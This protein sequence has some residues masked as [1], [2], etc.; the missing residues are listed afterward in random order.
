MAIAKLWTKHEKKNRQG[1]S[2]SSS[3]AELCCHAEDDL[4]AKISGNFVFLCP[5]K[6]P[7]GKCM[8]LRA[9]RSNLKQ[10]R[11]S[12]AKPGQPDNQR[13]RLIANLF[14]RCIWCNDLLHP[15]FRKPFDRYIAYGCNYLQPLS[16]KQAVIYAR[17]S[18]KEQDREGFSIPS[19][20]KLLRDY[21]A[22]HGSTVIHEFV[23]IET[24]KRTG[25]TYFNEMVALLKKERQKQ[26]G[27]CSAIYV[28]K[29]DRLYR[30]IKDWVTVDELDAEIHFVKENVV[31]SA[32]SRPSEKFMHGIKVLMAKNYIDN[33]SEETADEG[34]QLLE[35]VQHAVTTY[36][37][38][39]LSNK[40]SFLKIMHSNFFWKDG[41]LTPEYRQPFDFI[42]EINSEYK[43]KMAVS[44]EKNGHCPIWL[45]SR[46]RITDKVIL[47]LKPQRGP[48]T[49]AC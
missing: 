1:K 38:L 16:S 37:V 47:R 25:R 27:S 15:S 19:Q 35:L 6:R 24:A 3:K 40:G 32:E 48:S 46:T 23:D 9:T 44:R 45:P 11:K 18:S 22:Q 2:V 31:L 29:T 21:A 28:E 43:Q 36:K 10:R 14:S 17:V 33:L 5:R 20:L 39:D 8:K 26:S 4:Y 34:V 30:N 13:R 41:I 12:C 42:A 49:V 7:I